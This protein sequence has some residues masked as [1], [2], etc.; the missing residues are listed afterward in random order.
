MRPLQAL[1]SPRGWVP[2]ENSALTCNS[3]CHLQVIRNHQLSVCL[4][5]GPQKCAFLVVPVLKQEKRIPSKKTH[6]FGEKGAYE[7]A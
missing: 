3:S 7:S 1:F 6:T 5:A 4:K 2:Y